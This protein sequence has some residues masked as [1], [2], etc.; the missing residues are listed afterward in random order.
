MRSVECLAIGARA[1][2]LLVTAVAVVLISCG[3]GT[4]TVTTLT[5]GGLTG[6]AAQIVVQDT[7]T[8]P[9]T[10]EI[11]VDSG[12]PGAF[13][14]GV[15]NVPYVTVTLCSPG[16]TSRC[17]TIDHV[18]LDT[19]SI[20]LRILQSKVAALGLP[21]VA[22]PADASSATP[23]G[24]AAECYPF[25]LGAV[26]GPLATADLQIAGESALALTVQLIDD[27]VVPTFPAPA[28]CQAAASGGLLTSAATLQANGILGIGM[29]NVDCGVSCLTNVY[30]G[31]Y[32]VYYS[33]AAGSGTCV[34]AAMPAAAQ[35]HNPVS[36]FALDNNGAMIVMPALPDLGAAIAKG[37]LVFGIGTQANNQIPLTATMYRVDSDPASIN[38]LYLTT[39]LGSRSYPSSYIDTGSNAVFFDNATLPKACQVPAG[40]AGNWYC[41]ATAWRQTASIIDVAGTSGRIDFSVAS[42]DALFA[43]GGAA[44]ANLGG[45]AG[46]AASAFAWGMPFFYGRKVFVSIWGQ[47]LSPTGPWY[48]F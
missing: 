32:A 14:L 24:H 35:V 27:A 36:Q 39:Q 2:A 29:I 38:Y 9:N 37:R 13:S 19:G 3:G 31:S 23:A 18:L 16:S 4:T 34:P 11:V 17:V 5:G 20:G 33:C 40:T 28:N 8:G 6:G 26:W 7:P 48:A 21:Q 45:S 47:V 15:T 46:Q 43:T 44:F 30:S 42:A 10:T 12:P 25:V 41:P 1:R 22:V